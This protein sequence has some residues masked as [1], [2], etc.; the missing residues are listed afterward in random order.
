MCDMDTYTLSEADC[1]RIL[2]ATSEARQHASIVI[3]YQH[4]HYWSGSGKVN[5]EHEV[6]QRQPMETS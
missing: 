2:K 1:A 5:E 3:A 4:N 6:D